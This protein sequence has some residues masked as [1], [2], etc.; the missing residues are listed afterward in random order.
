VTTTGSTEAAPALPVPGAADLTAW[1]AGPADVPAL[2]EVA[3]ASD[4]AATGEASTSAEEV[5]EIVAGPDN[6]SWLVRDAAGRPVSWLCLENA[7]RTRREEFSA[8]AVPDRADALP[9]L[10][11]FLLGQV[12]AR[13]AEAG[14]PALEAEAAVL[15]VE[16]AYVE[17]LRSA[18]FEFVH[19]HARMRR[20]LTGPVEVPAPGEGVTV[21]RLRAGDED[22]LRM[23]HEMHQTAFRDT[24]DF[25]ARDWPAFRD[26]IGS[27][28]S[29]P[30]DQW[31]VAE[32]DAVP[33]ASLISSDQFAADGEGWVRS[34]AVLPRYRRRGLGRLL[35]ATAFDAYARAGRTRAGLGVDMANPTGAYALYEAVGMAPVFEA[36]VYAREVAAA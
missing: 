18:G 21:R 8:Y 30:W 22:D 23:V 24:R 17:A 28:S 16:K 5:A 19:R 1:P 29:V 13:A 20:E 11:A 27:W 25:V 36:D 15:P 14:R 12:A 31:F 7:G 26:W 3:Q 6:R 9:A 10:V 33:A 34:L 4:L 2:T 35:L 32:V